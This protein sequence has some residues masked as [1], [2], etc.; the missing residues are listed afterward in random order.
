MIGERTAATLEEF[1]AGL[2]GNALEGLWRV[3]T[4]SAEPRTEARPHVWRWAMLHDQ[5][6]QAGELLTL[7]RSA[8]RRVLLLVNPGL[9]TRIAATHTLVAAVQMI[10]PGEIAPTHRHSA[11]AIRFIIS[12][13]GAYTTVEGEQIVMRPGDLILTPNWT[14]H[15][16]GNETDAPVIWMDALDRPLVGALN[17]VFF[18]PYPAD[19]QPVTRPADFSAHVHGQP[20]RPLGE[21]QTTVFSPRRAYR[22]RDTYPTLACLAAAGAASPH[23]DV[24]VEYLNPT[25][26]G[27][28]LPTLGCVLQLLRPGVHTR[29]HR[30]TAS[31]VYH[32]FRGSGYSVIDGQ[33][34]DWARG[35]FLIVPPWAWHEH[36]NAS[37]R[38]EAILFS[39]N[40]LPALEA[41]ALCREEAYPDGDGHQT[42]DQV[43]S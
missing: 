27:H 38:E 30:H 10:K 17:T 43:S 18:E 33:R 34:F 19:R 36:A 26:G 42:V 32:V 7:D 41:L 1:Y 24:A 16:H 31:V 11:T 3:R 4:Q 15:D 29:A 21:R 13:Q 37:D 23:D 12:G 20:L 28:A 39:V 22:W 35:D 9:R 8:E 14:W 40:D 2:E 25:T 6:R 5:L